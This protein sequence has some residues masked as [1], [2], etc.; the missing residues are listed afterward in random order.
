[1]AIVLKKQKSLYISALKWFLFFIVVMVVARLLAKVNPFIT[2]ASFITIPFFIERI[3]NYLAGA[4]GEYLVTRQL[5]KL[6][7]NSYIINDINLPG[8]QIDHT[9]VCPKGIITI[10]TKTY[11]GKV[12]GNGKEK[13]WRQ[14]IGKNRF[15]IKR[16]SPIKQGRAHSVKLH[17]LL[18][19]RGLDRRID[20]LVVFAGT[21]EIKVRPRPIPVLYRKQLYEHLLNMP[22]VLSS[23]E[24]QN[25]KEMILDQIFSDNKL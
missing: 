8:L 12:Y 18:I 15:G 14:Y 13:Y 25:Y 2:I 11:V 10:E 21:A 22:D 6:G 23:E 19:K 7:D 4:L 1:M 20:T 24:I 16:Y 9:L 5:N 17:E 3:G